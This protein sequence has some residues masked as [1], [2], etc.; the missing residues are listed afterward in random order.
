MRRG[1]NKGNLNNVCLEG[2]NIDFSGECSQEKDSKH[3]ELFFSVKENGTQT[4]VG[5]HYKDHTYCVTHEVGK[6]SL[7][8]VTPIIKKIK[9][10]SSGSGQSKHSIELQQVMPRKYK[11]FS[12][13]LFFDHCFLG[14]EE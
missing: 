10:R 9:C 5:K 2:V 3:S 11:K 1:S 6:L 7:I 13:F 8:F 12:P 4:Q 14:P